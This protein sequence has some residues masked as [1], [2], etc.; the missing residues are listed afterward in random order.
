MKTKETQA[1]ID[2]FRIPAALLV[3]AIHNSPLTTWSEGADFFLTRVLARI[4]VPFFFMVTGQFVLSDYLL[5]A[6]NHHQK[7]SQGGEKS[8]HRILRYIQKILILYGISIVLY[9]PVGIY[10]GHYKNLTFGKV[11]RMLIFD[12][13]FYHLWYFPACIEGLLLVCL[14]RRFL[15]IRGTFLA[16]GLLYLIGLFGDSYFGLTEKL[17]VIATIYEKGFTLWSYTR[18]GLFMAPIFLILGAIV[19]NSSGRARTE[20]V[21]TGDARA[22]YAG[23]EYAR[24]ELVRAEYVRTEDGRTEFD[25]TPYAGTEDA[26][27]EHDRTE[28]RKKSYK[29]VYASIGFAC[30]FLL[31]TVEAFLLRHFKI[32]RHD[33]MYVMLIPTVIF[34]Y[35]ILLILSASTK[36][37]HAKGLR[38]LRSTATG[39]Y[40]L[41]PAMIV[42]V[43]GIA[44]LSKITALI[45]NSLLHYVSVVILTAA[46]AFLMAL[47]QQYVLR[48]SREKKQSTEKPDKKTVYIAQSDEEKDYLEKQDEEKEHFQQNRTWIE[49]DRKALKNNVNFFKEILPQNCRLMP[50]IKANAYGHGAVLLAK[51]L[52]RMGVNHFCV[53][54]IQEGIE[55]RRAGIQGEILILGYTHPAQ[56][57][58]LRKYHLSQ[59]VIDYAYAQ[60]LKKYGKKLH[61][62]VGIDTGMHRLGER[63]ENIEQICEIFEMSNLIVDGVMTHLS[64]DEKA[65]GQE[66]AFTD[67]QAA[68]FYEVL[69]VL[70]ARGIKCPKVHLQA[71]YG[72]LN[73]PELARDYAR[74]GIALYGVLSTKEDTL[75]WKKK[76]RPVLSLKTR[77]AVVKEIYAGEAAGYGLSFVAAHTMKVAVLTIGYADGF[78]RALSNGKGAVLLHGK[79]APVIGTICMDQ[80]LVD[81]SDIPD[82][83][84]G[85]IAVVIGQSGSGE[86][87]ACDLAEQAG[88]ITNEILSRIGARP[89]REIVSL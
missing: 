70:K 9:L 54:C 36:N 6:Q 63:C 72:V 16:A 62:H 71:S 42:V 85:D 83:H 2:F 75:S 11:L 33:S 79:K 37:T 66:K 81:V 23:I 12:G 59:T 46:A 77:V 68:A 67:H 24:T 47:L 18:N 53:A 29:K 87:T 1:G 31:M 50:A 3:V 27:K 80:T 5:G 8:L 56:F 20:N 21:R 40:I 78:P 88:T 32:Q 76:L 43:R 84:S 39:I 28:H 48:R 64:A 55:L 38:L 52:C 13:T 41:H 51:E 26:K 4:A 44:K 14:F 34:L 30:S 61:V 89:E 86:I 49:L 45:D 22:K 35:Q 74:V 57:D 19:G 10:A 73:Y 69:D 65:G 25:R 15:K 58:A 17:P 7:I 82:V 60:Q